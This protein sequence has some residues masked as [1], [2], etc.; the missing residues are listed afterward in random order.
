MHSRFVVWLGIALL[1]ALLLPSAA[2]AQ[3][4]GSIAGVVS[5]STGGILPGVRVEAKSPVLIEGSSGGVTDSAGRYTIVNLRPGT[6]TVTFTLD[7]FSALVREGV[8]LTGDAAVQVNAQ[9]SV[10]ALGE[11]ITVSGQ[12]PLVDVQQV[13][14]QFVATRGMMDLLPGA[15]NFST[16]AILIPGVRA[17]TGGAAVYWPALHG[18]T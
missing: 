12:S 17:D 8:L 15:N 18:S 3:A 14:G 5:D 11:T 2:L 4:G 7:G 16:R 6:Y 9:L 1:E 13:R 10:G